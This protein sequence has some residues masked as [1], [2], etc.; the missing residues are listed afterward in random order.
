[1]YFKTAIQKEQINKL[2]R[3]A[4]EIK[5]KR[6]ADLKKRLDKISD[7]ELFELAE[8]IGAFKHG[9]Q[10]VAGLEHKL[11]TMLHTSFLETRKFLFDTK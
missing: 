7:V 6:D 10:Q 8:Q 1:M 3:E 4:L 9:G 2:S 5:A 11:S